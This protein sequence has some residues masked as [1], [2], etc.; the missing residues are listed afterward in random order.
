MRDEQHA[1]MQAAQEHQQ[2][3]E[4]AGAL[5]DAGGAIQSVAAASQGTPPA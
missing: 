5:K 1:Q 3:V 2:A 4:T